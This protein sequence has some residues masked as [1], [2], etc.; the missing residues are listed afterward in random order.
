M[1]GSILQIE[2][3]I[4]V[5]ILYRVLLID[6]FVCFRTKLVVDMLDFGDDYITECRI[7]LKILP[8]PRDFS[9]GE[10]SFYMELIFFRVINGISL[11]VSECIQ[12]WTY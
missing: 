2:I 9:T 5:L 3:R 10:R 4:R 7:T 6:I 1:I 11:C 12:E 8:G